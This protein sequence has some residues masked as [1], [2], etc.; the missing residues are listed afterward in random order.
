MKLVL[1]SV[2]LLA[3]AFAGLAVKLIFRKNGEFAGT[4]ASR[5][6]MLSDGE[7]CGFC[8]ARPGEACAGSE[9]SNP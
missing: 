7:V 6:P 5:N 8:G 2:G 9:K 4:C 3:V 1:L